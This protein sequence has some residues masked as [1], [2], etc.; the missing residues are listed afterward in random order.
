MTIKIKMT[1]LDEFKKKVERLQKNVRE[2]GGKHEVSFTELFP[3]HFVSRNTNYQ[4]LQQMLDA[5]GIENPED[6]KGEVWDKFVAD[7]SR[8][9]GWQEMH[10]TAFTEWVRKKMNA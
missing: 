4:S 5:S 9:S 10:K 3:D 7:N 1:G 2:L 8:F 6:I